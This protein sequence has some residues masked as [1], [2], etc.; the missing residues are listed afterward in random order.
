MS[1]SRARAVNAACAIGGLLLAGALVQLGCQATASVPGKQDPVVAES[2]LR[3]N[4]HALPLSFEE[5]HGQSDKQVRFM[6]RGG[7][8][9]TFITPGESV[10]AIAPR[11]KAGRPGDKQATVK[12]RLDGS[13]RDAR[14]TGFD[15]LPGQANYF[16]GSDP[17]KWHTKIPTYA[18][19][20]C[21]QPVPGVD[22]VYYGNQRQLE[23]DYVVA[24]GTDPEKLTVCYDGVQ[25]ATVDANG[26]L[27][28]KTGVSDIRQPK[29]VAYQV[30]DAGRKVP[31]EARYEMLASAGDTSRVRF[32]L[33]SYDHR[34]SVVI[35][36]TILVWSTFIG[37]SHSDWALDVVTDA[38]GNAYVTGTT[39]SSNFPSVGLGQTPKELWIAKYNTIGQLQYTSF[40]GGTGAD[41]GAGIAVTSGGVVVVTGASQSGATP[42]IA[43][44]YPIVAGSL[45]PQL[46][47]GSDAVLSKLD[48][49]GSTLLYSTYIGGNGSDAGLAVAINSTATIAYVAGRTGTTG[50]FPDGVAGTNGF[51]TVCGNFDAFLEKISLDPSYNTPLPRVS[52]SYSAA[53]QYDKADCLYDTYIGGNANEAMVN[54]TGGE[55]VEYAIGVTA[56]DS[57]LAWVCGDTLSSDFPTSAGS[58][59]SSKP[60]AANTLDG[61]YVKIDTT[62]TGLS[63]RVWATYLGGPAGS[64]GTDVCYSCGIDSTGLPYVCGYTSSTNFPTVNAVYGTLKG[65]SDGF[66]AKLNSAGTALVYSTYLGGTG[67]DVATQM[68]VDSIGNAYVVG[69]TSSTDF[70]RMPNVPVQGTYATNTDFFITKFRPDGSGP[71]YSSYLGGGA[72]DK[73][74][75]LAVTSTGLAIVCGYTTSGGFPVSNGLN[76][77]G[78]YAAQQPTY[79]GGSFDGVVASFQLNDAPT[80]ETAQPSNVNLPCTVGGQTYN[81]SLNVKDLNSDNLVVQWCVKDPTDPDYQ[82]EETDTVAG[83]AVVL[84]PPTLTPTTGTVAFSRNVSAIG[85]TLFQAKLTDGLATVTYSWSVTF[86]DTAAPVFTA[87]LSGSLGTL[88]LDPTNPPACDIYQGTLPIPAVTDCQNSTVTGLIADPDSGGPTNNGDPGMADTTEYART[89]T[90]GSPTWYFKVGETYNVTWTAVDGSGNT[91]YATQTVVVADV[92]PPVLVV[93]NDVTVPQDSGLDGADLTPQELGILGAPPSGTTPQ[94]SATDACGVAFIL[95]FRDRSWPDAPGELGYDPTDPVHDTGVPEN[96]EGFYPLGRSTLTWIAYDTSL[97]YTEVLQ[98]ITVTG[99]NT[100]SSNFSSSDESWTTYGTDVTAVSY[101]STGGNPGGNISASQPS[102]TSSTWFFEAPAAFHAGPFAD[103]LPYRSGAYGQTLTFDLKIS[104]TATISSNEGVI[105]AGGGL[106]IYAPLS[107]TPTTAWTSESLTLS[108]ATA[109]RVDDGDGNLANDVLA[110]NAQI[111][112]TLGSLTSLKIRGKFLATAGAATYLDNV[113]LHQSY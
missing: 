77:V 76:P 110:T 88:T 98:T 84:S 22:V 14:V 16:I 62:T 49:N 38:A 9:M 17:K 13:R 80:F 33:G 86:T 92:L 93:P 45:Q 107:A 103:F 108:T 59:Q 61:F 51:D 12:V 36:P 69:Y 74:T 43:N 5:N 81:Y 55:V 87:A 18:K 112:T 102:A 68:R 85:T 26:D 3:N 20:K 21:E 79:G 27:L 52:S 8:Y 66:V 72:T 44:N 15:R 53:Y 30:D 56:N 48:T 111:Q 50:N 105:L 2:R 57:G 11:T 70:Q 82:L 58:Y 78:L 6:A 31:V 104:G 29:P 113:I 100:V 34:R 83:P 42:S 40:L 91:S 65:A 75:S 19:V 24:P 97:N 1:R 96:N 25:K 32:D 7:D 63:S 106:T 95:A 90:T 46:G 94:Y 64:S 28:L 99:T 47:G 67:S 89:I 60:G 71:I 41:N 109:W 37:G 23:Y 54:V 39:V 35:D 4:L 101:N 73:A 10:L